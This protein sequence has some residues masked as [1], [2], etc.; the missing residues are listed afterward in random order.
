MT[1][2]G[3]FHDEILWFLQSGQLQGPFALPHE[4]CDGIPDIQSIFCFKYGESSKSLATEPRTVMTGS[5]VQPH[6]VY[7]CP[8]AV[9]APKQDPASVFVGTFE[10]ALV[11]LLMGTV[12]PGLIASARHRVCR[13]CATVSGSPSAVCAD[14]IACSASTFRSWSSWSVSV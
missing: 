3:L 7:D 1:F 13:T 12:S 14:K 4:A 10:A 9:P 5:H 2:A 6:N 8:G 11:R